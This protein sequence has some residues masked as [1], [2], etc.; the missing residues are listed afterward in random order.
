MQ[1]SIRLSN[2]KQVTITE[3]EQGL[4][5][6]AANEQ[7]DPQWLLSLEREGVLVSPHSG[8]LVSKLAVGLTGGEPRGDLDSEIDR[9]EPVFAE[10]YHAEQ[11]MRLGTRDILRYGY[12]MQGTLEFSA[13][14]FVAPER[15]ETYERRVSDL[16][17]SSDVEV[18]RQVAGAVVIAGYLEALHHSPTESQLVAATLG[19]A[20]RLAKRHLRCDIAVLRQCMLKYV[21]RELA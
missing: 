12:A 4:H 18:V 6:A 19:R 21:S 9:V 17:G 8:H 2:D 7:G 15:R 10:Y 11:R 5:L 13:F 3:S 14:P 1:H 20:R 16:I